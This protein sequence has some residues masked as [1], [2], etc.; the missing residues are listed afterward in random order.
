MNQRQVVALFSIV[1]SIF[2]LWFALANQG[3]ASASTP[4][5]MFLPQ[6]QVVPTVT[7][8]SQEEIANEALM[9]EPVLLQVIILLAVV[10]VLV[11]FIGV[12]IN[13]RRVDLR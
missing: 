8:T 5:N 6:V 2:V 12:W 9:T 13:S 3:L 4:S 10:A 7:P 11:V 1:I